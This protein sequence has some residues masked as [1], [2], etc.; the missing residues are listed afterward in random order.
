LILSQS[1]KVD[2]SVLCTELT[3]RTFPQWYAVYTRSR[4][5]KCVHEQCQRRSIESFLPLYETVRRWKDRRVRV[6]LP[7]FPS[8]VFVRIDLIHRL[9]VL[10]IPGVASLVGFGGQPA[11][12]NEEEIDALQK[13]LSHGVCAIPHP[14][15]TKGR[16][17]RMKAGPLAGLE[18]ILVRRKGNLRVVLSIDLLQRSIAVDTDIADLDLVAVSSEPAPKERFCCA[19]R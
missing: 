7:L 17:V 11:V 4:H 19:S 12:L 16:R 5:E 10:Q 15:L 8:Y 1:G 14:N 9:D 3:A 18:G 13:G 6:P 2:G